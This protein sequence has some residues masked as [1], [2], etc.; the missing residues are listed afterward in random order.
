MVRIRIKR[1]Y[2]PAE[3][4]DGF[5]VLVDRLWP[6][7]LKKESVRIDLW[8]KDLAPSTA[9]R[10]WVHKQPENWPEFE[11][12]YIRE[13]QEY[14]GMNEVMAQLR[15]QKVVTLLYAARNEHRN[16]ALVLQDFINKT[17]QASS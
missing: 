12:R 13:L 8:A 2:E 11:D 5:R 10:Q 7:G 1:I 15:S 14:S 6:R 4:S 3:A 9:L 17:L 16:H